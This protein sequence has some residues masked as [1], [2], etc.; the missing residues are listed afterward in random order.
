MRLLLV[1]LALSLGLP[2]CSTAYLF[3]EQRSFYTLGRAA[4]L[5]YSSDAA[6]D[7]ETPARRGKTLH[8]AVDLRATNTGKADCAL[9][10]PKARFTEAGEGL[11]VRCENEKALTLPPGQTRKFSCHARAELPLAAGSP[12]R[13]KDL[14]GAFT[15]P[16]NCGGESATISAPYKLKIED[17]QS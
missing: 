11:H 4:T 17:F 5:T 9:D 2:A 10:L 15:L 3:R 16:V 14:I 8:W 6:E 7:L 12:L 13:T 1:F